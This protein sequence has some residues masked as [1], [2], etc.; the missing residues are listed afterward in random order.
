IDRRVAFIRDHVGADRDCVILADYQAAYFMETGLRSSL[1]APGLTEIFFL[2]DLEQLREDLVTNPPRHLFV[3][4]E[5]VGKLG[6]TG[7]VK[8][9]YKTVETFPDGKLVY[10]EPR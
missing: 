1:D 10:L 4:E 5:T 7:T 2:K 6:L 3:D 8:D 9:N